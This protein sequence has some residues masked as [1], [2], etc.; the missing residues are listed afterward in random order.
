[1]AEINF[2]SIIFKL[3]VQI[4]SLGTQMNAIQPHHGKSTLVEA[5][6]H[7]MLG[8]VGSGDG[9]VLSSNKPLPELMMT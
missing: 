1:M 7:N 3:I 6:L 9:L 5:T 2:K 8:G 4:S